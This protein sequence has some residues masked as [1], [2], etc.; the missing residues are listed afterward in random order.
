MTKVI[1]DQAARDKITSK[2]GANF[3]VEAGAGSGKTTS[4]V[5]RMVNLIQ[6]GTAEIQEIVAITFTRKAADELKVRFQAKLE[7]AW[8]KEKN[9]DAEYRLDVALK[10]IERCFI[11]TVHAFCAK[12]L[13]ERPIEAHLD[14]TFK[15]LE[16][17]DDLDILAEAWQLYLQELMDQDSHHF[18]E[19][20]ELGI[21]VDD[22][23]PW[24]KDLKEYSD[25]EWVTETVSKPELHED[26]KYFMMLIQEA[27]KFIPDTEPLKG[28]DALQ[29]AIVTACQKKK[30]IDSLQDK[31]II[32]IFSLFAKN[33]KPTYNRWP[34]KE[35]AQYYQ[36]K[37][38]AAFEVNINPLIQAWKEHCHPKIV[39][40][41][42]GAVQS[43]EQ[44]KKERSL[45]NFQD[46]MMHTS[47]L[48]KEIREVRRYF[49][50]KYRFLLVDEFQDTDP[51][52]AEIMFY[53]T[54]EDSAEK[55]WTSCKPKPGS[56]FVV[57]DP[58]Q[59]IYRFRRADI[60]TYNRV[61]QLMEE[62]G[63][64]VL[65]LT[66]NFRTLDTVT[67]P[68]NTVFE[69]HL[70]IV[71]TVYQAAYRPL[72]SYHEDKGIGFSGVKLLSVPADVKKKEEIMLKDAENIA[73]TIHNL[74]KQGYRAKDFMVLTRYNDGIATYAK[75]IEDIGIPVSISGEV[76]LGE[77]R[78]FQDLWI[79]LKSFL[80]PT[81][82][83]G[84][85][86]VLRGIFFGI[87][88]EELY[89][90]KQAKGRFSVYADI[91]D[92]LSAEV[93]AKFALA[94]SKLQHCQ[95]QILT[96]SPTAAIEK[97]SEE[98]GFYPLLLTN[99][100][101]KRMYKSLLQVIEALRKQEAAGNT[102]YKQVLETL[103]E[104]I[105]EKTV[106]TN[107][108][109]EADAVRIM[110]VHKAKGLEA[111]IVFL[112][113]P[114][115]AVSPESFLSKHIKREDLSSK[116]FFTFTV[117]TGYQSKEMAIPLNWAAHKA[118]ELMYLSEEELRI[119]YVASTRAEKALII[120]A[121]GSNKKNPWN[122][123]F[124]METI[125]ELEISELDAVA[126]KN[127]QAEITLRDFQS[128]TISKHV[129]IDSSSE[130]SYDLWT[131]TKDKDYSVITIERESG[132][133][134]D[135]GTLIHDVL[136]KAVQ[137]YDLT[138]YLKTAL[139]KF[140]LPPARE[141][142]VETYL[143]NL[144]KSE[145]W[146]NLQTAEE[147][148]TEVPFTLKV[149]KGHKLYPLITKNPIDKHPFFVKG[150]IDLIYKRHGSWTIVDYKTDRAKHEEDYDTLQSFYSSQL[151]FYK[152]AWEALTGEKVEAECLYFL[153]P[154]RIAL[155]S[156]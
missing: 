140:K 57:G 100:R 71:E 54:S 1:Q 60:D 118:E 138:H 96:F 50:G 66:T 51:L 36:E 39:S 14:L 41:L 33:L 91:P 30:F 47:T 131:P 6:T 13:R 8:K 27:K 79:L 85:V 124:E 80:D 37:I 55:N 135:W 24:L 94:L 2:L 29:K 62:H 78:E 26:Y 97:I 87:S 86:A 61:K 119:I 139:N 63:G 44:L 111:P 58:K 125:E 84:F 19:I 25:V 149:E 90:W 72:I 40:F 99:G 34:S 22:I 110:N 95:K 134:K 152:D 128:K 143:Q 83:V 92:G 82:E 109:E 73:L 155:F 148:L 89:Q 150:T 77:T 102:T 76:I 130:K 52:Q 5:E 115:K 121:N 136:E 31:D 133:G 67:K 107:L 49:Q 129:W 122:T 120:S 10:N 108:E 123:L 88:D 114:A 112:A 38:T 141:A 75:R 106:V 132:G 11:G 43:Y 46:L 64:E 20:A 146:G 104:M 113:H 93:K 42:K 12:L 145:L 154:N 48:L 17:A 35:D 103:T 151:A 21:N 7:E 32:G 65:Q 70:P 142:E 16:E 117:D 56:L 9:L 3:L 4:L 116:G 137:G 98:I 156:K 69:Q 144:K 18:G 45:L 68:L 127:P 105:F 15:E 59:A 81:D 147:V 126:R 101:G 23:F 28:Y 74:L 53:L 153:T